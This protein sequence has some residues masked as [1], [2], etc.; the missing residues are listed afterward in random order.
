MDFSAL[1][2]FIL[3]PSG[4]PVCGGSFYATENGKQSTPNCTITRLFAVLT[5]KVYFRGKSH[6]SEEV[7]KGFLQHSHHFPL[8]QGAAPRTPL[9]QASWKASGW[10]PQ[11]MPL[12]HSHGPSNPTALYAWAYLTAEKSTFQPQRALPPL[13]TPRVGETVLPRMF[14]APGS[15]LEKSGL[16]LLHH[17]HLSTCKAFPSLSQTYFAAKLWE[18]SQ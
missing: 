1:P 12:S 13:H 2:S 5:W 4:V 14:S 10:T 18:R 16:V 17:V 3:L 6:C 15:M 11:K 7:R 8:A 9:A